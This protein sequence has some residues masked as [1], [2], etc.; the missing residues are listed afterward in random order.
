[1]LGD[2][3]EAGQVQL[4]LCWML[5]QAAAS[6]QQG[7]PW[8]WCRTQAHRTLLP[9]FRCVVYPYLLLPG[10]CLTGTFAV[11]SAVRGLVLHHKRMSV[12]PGQ[13][14]HCSHGVRLLHGT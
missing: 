2:L 12:L 6:S 3:Q 14:T 9:R 7:R 5:L 10:S 8:P 1:M 4:R 11:I 13:V